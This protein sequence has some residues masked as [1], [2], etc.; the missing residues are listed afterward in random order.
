MSTFSEYAARGNAL[1]ALRSSILTGTL[2]A[3][4][5][6]WANAIREITRAVLPQDTLDVVLAE[7][8]AAGITTLLGVGVALLTAR[9]WCQRPP[10]APTPPPPIPWVVKRR[11]PRA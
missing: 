8:L 10:P 2:W 5:I 11:Q 4:G 9:Q 3:I 1:G 7:L 6:A